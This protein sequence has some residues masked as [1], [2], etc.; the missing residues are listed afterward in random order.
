MKKII[1]LG[2]GLTGALLTAVGLGIRL[3]NKGAED[4][5]NEKIN[6][7]KKNYHDDMI[8]ADEAYKK[9]KKSWEEAIEY[10]NSLKECCDDLSNK[11]KELEKDSS[12]LMK[13]NQEL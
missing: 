5:Y 8:M 13:R 3:G 2:T 4:E 7:I 11:N 10:N 1:F 9:V 6:E 12:N